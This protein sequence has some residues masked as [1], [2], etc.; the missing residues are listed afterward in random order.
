MKTHFSALKAYFNRL[1]VRVTQSSGR[2]NLEVYDVK[3][4]RYVVVES[5]MS[6][7]K[8]DNYYLVRL[9]NEEAKLFY[10]NNKYKKLVLKKQG[11]RNGYF[12]ENMLVYQRT[13][14]HW[15]A[16]TLDDKKVCMGREQFLGFF[17]NYHDKKYVVAYL[18]NKDG[19]R[20]WQHS[21]YVDYRPYKQN[22]LLFKKDNGG[23]DIMVSRNRVLYKV[24]VPRI[25]LFDEDSYFK[26]YVLRDVRGELCY[27]KSADGHGYRKNRKKFIL[28]RRGFWFWLMNKKV[29]RLTQ[30]QAF[31]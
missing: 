5:G 21:D 16:K 11:F 8:S 28:F 23:C 4:K 31:G 17:A 3:K 30:V 18:D 7:L 10:A 15:Y 1:K 13:D 29:N 12:N 25:V 20:L 27:V 19:K 14:L 22:Y 24:M 2:Y 9:N 26:V 6:I